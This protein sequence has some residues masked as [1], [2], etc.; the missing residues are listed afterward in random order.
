MT[1]EINEVIASYQSC[2]K[3]KPQA[4]SSVW[5]HLRLRTYEDL[6]SLA[7]T[8]TEE[9]ATEFMDAIIHFD[10]VDEKMWQ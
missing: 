5:R 10:L 1:L 7:G 4:A 9:Q 6:D 2:C 8:W 3:V